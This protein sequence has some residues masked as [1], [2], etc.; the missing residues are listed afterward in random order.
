MS[1]TS[2]LTYLTSDLPGVGGTIKLRP[3]DFFVEEQPLYKTAGEGEHLYLLIE[4]TSLTTPEVVRRLAR[5]FRVAR[6]SIGYAGMKDKHAVTRQHF[7]IRLPP[8]ADEVEPLN[9]LANDPR[10]KVLWADRHLNK[11]RRGHLAS[12]RFV[13]Y[14]RQVN[15]SDAIAARRVL[16]RL[17][18]TGIPN[19]IGEQRFGYR[20]NSHLLGR[21]LLLADY[22]S[23][24]DEMLGRPGLADSPDLRAGRQAYERGDYTAAL[25]TWPRQ[26]RF[27]RQAMDALRQGCSPAEAVGRIEYQQRDFLVSALQ[28][29]IFN[30]VLDYRLRE[31]VYDRLLPGDLAWKHDS[32]AVFEVDEQVASEDNQS[33][34]RVETLQVSPS[35]PLWGISMQRAAGRPGEIERQ[36]LGNHDL[37]ESQLGGAGDIKA[38]GSRRPLRQPVDNPDISGGVDEHGSFIRVAFE[39]QRGT[40]AT[41][42]LREI[43]KIQEL[44]HRRQEEAVARNAD[45]SSHLDTAPICSSTDPVPQGIEKS[46]DA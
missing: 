19:F 25:E 9:R 3:E 18:K 35:G 24:V 43:M 32:R 20:Q 36:A 31:A 2:R 40:Y 4:K 33:G 15:P 10:L 11:L 44:E 42:V 30:D 39:L 29:A 28:S 1:L 27:D 38:E 16:D 37:F 6:Q 12:N 7:S 17:A 46:A 13:I 21:Y 41:I 14:L 23:F 22:Q 34:G 8:P 45:S 5:A 26:L